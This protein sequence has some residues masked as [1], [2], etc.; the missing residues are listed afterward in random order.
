MCLCS[1]RRSPTAGAIHLALKHLTPMSPPPCPSPLRLAD[2]PGRCGVGRGVFQREA[3]HTRLG[4]TGI[5]THQDQRPSKD[6][7]RLSM[8]R[9]MTDG[10]RC[11]GSFKQCSERGRWSKRIPELALRNSICSSGWLRGLYMQILARQPCKS[12]RSI[13]DSRALDG[14]ACMGSWTVDK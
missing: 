12:T 4:G 14:I 2:L 10:Q 13:I 8:R 5:A 6:N 7:I 1:C 3:C 11:K 9:H